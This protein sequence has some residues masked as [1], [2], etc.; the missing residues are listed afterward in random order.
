LGWFL[1]MGFEGSGVKELLGLKVTP[2]HK[3]SKR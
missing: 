2:K 3:R 1:E